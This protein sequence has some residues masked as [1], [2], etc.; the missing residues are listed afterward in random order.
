MVSNSDSARTFSARLEQLDN[1]A[2]SDY[3]KRVGANL[4]A[5]FPGWKYQVRPAIPFG[6]R[7]NRKV[8][9]DGQLGV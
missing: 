9:R 3:V 8:G 1:R 7:V 4:A 6:S 2:A 5:Q